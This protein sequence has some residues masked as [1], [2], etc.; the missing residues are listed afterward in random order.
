MSLDLSHNDLCDLMDTVRKLQS[1]PKLQ[2]LILQGNPL[3]VGNIQTELK[4]RD[5]SLVPVT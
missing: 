3:S 2:N 5:S 1:L 4:A